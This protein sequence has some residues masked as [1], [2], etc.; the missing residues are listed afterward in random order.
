MKPSLKRLREVASLPTCPF[1]EDA[2]IDWLRAFAR[3]RKISIKQDKAGNLTFTYKKGRCKRPLVL[4]AHM[5]HPGLEV[6]TADKGKGTGTIMGGLFPG[7]FKSGKA[8]FDVFASPKAR[9]VK[10]RAFN[11]RGDAR[12]YQ[13]DISY[14]AK[15]KLKKGDWGM[16]GV[17]PW[18]EKNGLLHNR[19]F[20]DLAQVAAICETFD[21]LMKK[22]P[23][24]AHVI[25]LFTRAE[26]VGFVG[27][28]ACTES[29]PPPRNSVVIS[30]ECSSALPVG[31]EQGKGVILR[32]GDRLT[33]FSGDAGTF[34][35]SVAVGLQA[36]DKSFSYQRRLM[37]GGACEGSLFAACGFMTGALALP[38][39]N[40]HNNGKTSLK[41][42][43]IHKQ[44]YVNLC[45]YMY[46]LCLRIHDFDPWLKG[47]EA[48]LKT[49]YHSLKGRLKKTK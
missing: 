21:V 25:G 18:R 23:D 5:D 30:L 9:P 36:K 6:E 14:P 45:K 22:K 33:V 34:L 2:V 28:A 7:C 43:T 46:E 42:E 29:S 44:D 48:R 3:K 1:Y 4:M 47:L 40:Y 17:G 15:A 12:P 32:L 49:S 11:L 31:G 26:E 20:D 16:V 37:D 35:N 41:P 24:N 38:L 19:V 8:T 10:V 39:G 27:A 13:V